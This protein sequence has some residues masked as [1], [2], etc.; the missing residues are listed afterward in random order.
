MKKGFTLIE[1][2]VVVLI[3][4]ILSAVALPSYQMAV[5][6]SRLTKVLPMMKAIKQA[7]QLYYMANGEY[8]NDISAWDISMPE[9]T[10]VT[11]SNGDRLGIIALP[12]GTHFETVAAP[13][14]GGMGKP[15]VQGHPKDTPVRLHFFYETDEVRCYPNDSNMGR[16]LCLNLG[17]K[18]DEM[19][20]PGSGSGCAFSF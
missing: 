16:R 10:T 11:L 3:I 1:L 4:G 7:N 15:R 9:G 18:K 2:L 12:D 20:E 19:P 8:T 14:E 13:I 17:C 6:K 5:Y